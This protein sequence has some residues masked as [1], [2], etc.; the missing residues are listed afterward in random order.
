VQVVDQAT[1]PDESVMLWPPDAAVSFYAGR[2]TPLESSNADVIFKGWLPRL[3]PEMPEL[4][5]RLQA[6]PP[7]VIIDWSRIKVRVSS[8]PTDG[9]PPSPTP[10]GDGV[11][12]P[13]E[14]GA[15]DAPVGEPLLLTSPEGF[16]LLEPPNDAHPRPEGR[17]LAPLKRWIRANYGG[18]RREGPAVLFFRVRPWRDWEDVLLPRTE[19]AD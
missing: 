17:A 10:G 16:S 2:R 9:R 18:Q 7:D 11:P 19:S 5:K 6:D 3:S 13:T 4:I 12:T 15:G 1:E 8:L 14:L